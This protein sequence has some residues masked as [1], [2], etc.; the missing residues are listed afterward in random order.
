[1][2][3]GWIGIGRMGQAMALRLLKAGH[4]LSIWNRTRAK[5]EPMVAHGAVLADRRSQLSAHDVVFTM[6]GT[7]SDLKDVLFGQDGV[8]GTG[9][10]GNADGKRILVDCST[11]GADESEEIDQLLARQ[12]WQFLSAPVSGNP[13]CV[14]AGQLSSIVSGPKA[15]FDRVEPLIRTYAPRGVVYAGEGALARTCKVAHNVFLA[16]MIESLIEV[17]LLAQKAGVPR[18]AFLK[19][20]NGSVLGSVFTGYKSSALVNLDFKPTFT[21][22]LLRKDVDLGLKA[23]HTLEMPMPLTAA[24]RELIQA[25]IGTA[26]SRPDPDAYLAQDF[27][28]LIETLA[29]HAGMKLESENVPMPSGLT[30]PVNAG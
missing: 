5:A 28:A 30:G 15:A 21:I 8:A 10:A 19:F 13:L 26:S 27:A 12:G 3:I 1:M 18:H 20:I 29:M 25:H 7:A 4:P 6:L 16:A 9:G 17:T 14:A 23:A 24:L 11:I 2:R 22:E